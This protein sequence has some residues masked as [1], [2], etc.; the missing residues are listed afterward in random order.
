MTVLTFKDKMKKKKKDTMKIIF[1]KSMFSS[2]KNSIM[3]KLI[4][5]Q[6]TVFKAQKYMCVRVFGGAGESG[7]ILQLIIPM[8]IYRENTQVQH[9][10]RLAF[11]VNPINIHLLDGKSRSTCQTLGPHC[12]LL[13]QGPGPP[14]RGRQLPPPLL[15]C[16]CFPC[17][18]NRQAMQK[19]ILSI[20]PIL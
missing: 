18:A 10:I 16:R 9:Y 19:G 17:L 6:D 7:S 13:S 20:Q 12:G 2:N 1:G 8:T 4:P 5:L 15:Y 3:N 11:E 14:P